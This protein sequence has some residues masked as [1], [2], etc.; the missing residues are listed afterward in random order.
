MEHI[1]L[2]AAMKWLSWMV[3]EGLEKVAGGGTTGTSRV[4]VRYTEGVPEAGE[5][6]QFSHTSG[7][8]T[9]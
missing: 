6:V 5:R 8:P 9:F 1:N 7:V 4:L 2:R 3:P